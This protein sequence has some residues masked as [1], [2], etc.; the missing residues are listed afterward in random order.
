[1]IDDVKKPFKTVQD[2]VEFMEQT[3]KRGER[4][5]ILN[6]E[7]L[8]AGWRSR[9]MSEE[10]VTSHSEA[11]IL[12]ECIHLM[13][14]MIGECEEWY[15]WMHGENAINELDDE[16]MFRFH[17]SYFSIVQ[18]LFLWHTRHGGGTSTIQKCKELGI[19]DWSRD[20]EFGFEK[21]E[22]YEDE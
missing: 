5:K 14:E 22:D 8:P 6:S 20:V 13:H 17:K 2:A 21:D 9:R 7:D 1:M 10:K 18:Q 12:K 3:E 16:E 4:F 15:K 11:D 19:K